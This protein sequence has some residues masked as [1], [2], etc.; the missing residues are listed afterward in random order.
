MMALPDAA[1]APPSAMRQCTQMD[2]VLHRYNMQRRFLCGRAP[3]MR[4]KAGYTVVPGFQPSR[5][6]TRWRGAIWV[7]S[8]SSPCWG[9]P[10]AKGQLRW[11]PLT[12]VRAL[13]G[14]LLFQ[15]KARREAGSAPD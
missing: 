7:G 5:S 8:I 3:A 1:E 13:D 15:G 11:R 2:W 9:G 12:P 10:A 14:A 4:V 6:L